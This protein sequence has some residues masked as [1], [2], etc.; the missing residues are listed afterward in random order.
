MNDTPRQSGSRR[1]RAYRVD[2]PAEQEDAATALLWEAGTTGI[3][4]QT[5]PDGSVGML[6]CFEQDIDASLEDAMRRLGARLQAVAVPDMDWVARFREGFRA[7][8]AG[9]FL[10]APPWGLPASVP[11][12]ARLLVVDPGRAFGTGTHESTRLCLRALEGLARQAALRRVLDVGTGAGI[13]AV[14]AALLGA[15]EVLAVDND[16]EALAA[17]REHARLNGVSV[18]LVLGDAGRAFRPAACDLVLANLTAPLLL[19]RAAEVAALAR[20]GGTLV[21]A[22]LLLEEAAAVADA[23]APFGAV[24][25]SQDGEW[26]GLV[27]TR[28]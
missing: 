17:A 7:F 12:G 22:G 25:R 8:T 10:I 1:V 26:A 4:V 13:L 15:A 28:R 24:S 11:R 23:Y 5:G 18:R 6:A 19:E 3:E 20:T 9:G 21:L 2:L 14:A 16:P 27:V